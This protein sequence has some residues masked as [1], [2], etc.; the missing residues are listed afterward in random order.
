MRYVH[1]SRG[2]VA[3]RRFEIVEERSARFG[4]EPGGGLVEQQQPRIDRE[5]AREAHPL[6]FAA[7][8]RGSLPV[9]KAR[10]VEAFEGCEGYG[11]AGRSLHASPAQRKLDIAN[12]AGGEQPGA[13]CRVADPAP[14]VDRGAGDRFPVD[15]DP[16]RR[17]YFETGE[18]PEQG[19]LAGAVRTEH[20]EPL[21]R[22]QIKLIDREHVASAT[23]VADV[24]DAYDCAHEAAR[25]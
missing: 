5:R 2:A 13:L 4:V 8:E 9:C 11:S 10:D 24:A 1:D 19:R 22:F 18:Q 12:H 16:S 23:A 3:Q 6:R 14:D 21:A 20:R 25:C 17:R 15:L 7:R